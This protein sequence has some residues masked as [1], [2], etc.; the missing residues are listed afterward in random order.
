MTVE[1]TACKL[2]YLLGRGDLSQAEVAELMEVNLRGELTPAS[3]L[4]PPPLSST[5]QQAIHKQ[6]A[7][8]H[9]QPRGTEPY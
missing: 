6:Q 9:H 1:A 7:L 5:Y 8:R 2:A 3:A 4:S